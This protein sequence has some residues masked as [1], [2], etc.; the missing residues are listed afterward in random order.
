M[1]AASKG[2]FVDTHDHH[3]M[4]DIDVGQRAVGAN[5]IAVLMAQTVIQRFTPGVGKLHLQSFR[6]ALIRADLQRMI[7][8]RRADGVN[9]NDIRELRKGAQQLSARGLRSAQNASA[10]FSEEWVVHLLAQFRTQCHVFGIELI[11][12]EA[13]FVVAVQIESTR[14]H[15]G[16]FK[17]RAEWKFA[18][19]IQIHLA[20]PRR[21]DIGGGRLNPVAKLRQHTARRSGRRRNSQRV[22]V[23]QRVD[24]VNAIDGGNPSTVHA[25]AHGADGARRG[26][27]R[28]SIDMRV[29]QAQ[30][31]PRHKLPA[32][33]EAR[34]NVVLV[35]R[36]LCSRLAVHADKDQATGDAGDGLRRGRRN[37]RIENIRAVVSL[38]ARKID[39]PTQADAEAEFGCNAPIVMDVAGN[40]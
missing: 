2:Q 28:R 37:L 24:R 10:E 25:E 27:L 20:G 12:A 23:A 13:A 29:A 40:I 22:G 19:D 6:E 30:N 8:G 1:P 9:G 3:P 4:S 26:L 21:D 35:R 5:V 14:A 34:S 17:Q 16:D 11:Q 31:C 33:S 38:R 7:K 18:L 39:I 36:E 15:I 32:Q